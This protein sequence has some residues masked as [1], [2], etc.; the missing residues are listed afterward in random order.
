[1]ISRIG[2]SVGFTMIELM[3]AVVVL[4]V[5]LVLILQSLSSGMRALTRAQNRF[6]AASIAT[7]KLEELEE[8][9]IR[10]NGLGQQL[11][12]REK[13]TKQNKDFDVSVEVTPQAVDMER[14]PQDFLPGEEPIYFPDDI[15][16][17]KIVV[18]VNWQERARPQELVLST[19]LNA[20][21]VE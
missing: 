1:M 21:H 13:I 6:L 8:E 2:R 4:T 17:Q 5:G 14:F 16:V 15:E 12:P 9:E 19:Y 3:L 10:E 18:C 7:E 11:I 20:K